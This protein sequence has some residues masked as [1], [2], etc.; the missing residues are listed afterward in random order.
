MS[1]ARSPRA[2]ARPRR[3]ASRAQG[4]RERADR[5]S[6]V[7]R[8]P[9][10]ARRAAERQLSGQRPRRHAGAARPADF[11]ARSSVPATITPFGDVLDQLFA[12]NYPT[13]AVGVSVSYPIGGSV[14]QANYARA[15]LESR[16]GGTAAEERRGARHSAGARR[17]VEDR[18]ERQ[19]DRDD[20]R[21]ARA[22]AEQRLDAERKR[23]EVGMSTSFLR[24][25]GAARSRA[26]EDQRAV[27]GAR[28][29]SVARRLRGAA[30]GR[31]RRFRT[32]VRR[33]QWHPRFH[34]PARPRHARHRRAPSP[35]AGVLLAPAATSHRGYGGRF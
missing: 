28:L 35:L 4:H 19:A 12:S 27:G 15:Q 32:L 13:W 3:P 2:L 8:Q 30:A 1:R 10:A 22:L 21:G 23:F 5:R 34:G 33:C 20:A 29:R 18:D 25:S 16:A 31:A 7:H 24:H 11:P 26:G 6:E 9:A 14:E 17:R